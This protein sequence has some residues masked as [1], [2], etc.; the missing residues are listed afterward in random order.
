MKCFVLFFV[1]LLVFL[2]DLQCEISFIPSCRYIVDVSATKDRK[3]ITINCNSRST[4]EVCTLDCGIL[5]SQQNDALSGS[6]CWNVCSLRTS[7]SGRSGGGTGKRR[8][9]GIYISGI[10]IPFPIPLWLPFDWAV[11][12]PPINQREAET[13]A[14]VNK[15]WKTR[16]KG[17]D[18]IT[19]V[20]SANQYFASTFPCR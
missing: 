10:W 3:F 7:S 4:S 16:A 1:C 5:K 8:R 12:L 2:I 6:V 14:N 18:V 15:Y 9:A 11:R 17:N 19:N 13:S 20:I